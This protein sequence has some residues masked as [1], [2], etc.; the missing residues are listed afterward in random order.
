MA[1]LLQVAQ[2]LIVLKLVMQ[3]VI[4]QTV[5]AGTI[6][7]LK[8]N[9]TTA[10]LVNSSSN[11]VFFNGASS[12]PTLSP[13]TDNAYSC[14]FSSFR[15]TVIYATTGTINTS[16]RNEKQDIESLSVAELA[17]ARRIKSLIKSLDLKMQYKV[18]K[19]STYSRRCY[20][21][22]STRC[23]YCRRP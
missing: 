12:P 11:G 4:N 14:G 10:A 20:C 19:S 8:S 16:D 21:S 15:W 1:I 6:V 2:V 23:F 5:L 22:R 18:K 9:A 17:V 3:P 7:G 13:T